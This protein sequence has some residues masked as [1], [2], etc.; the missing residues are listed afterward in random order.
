[1]P[2]LARVR[3]L[4]D[5]DADPSVIDQHLDAG[6][7]G[8]LVSPRPGLRVP[9]AVDAFEVAVSLTVGGRRMAAL[10]RRLSEPIDTGL[11]S[12]DR[13]PLSAE[14]V[15]DARLSTLTAAQLPRRLAV[16]VKTLARR[17]ADGTLSL[18]EHTA[19]PETLERL[20]DLPEIDRTTAELI[21]MRAMRWPDAFPATALRH[22]AGGLSA[23]AL[24][25]RAERWRPWRAYAAMRL[26]STV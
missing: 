21:A 24:A 6:G 2:L 16:C 5:L 20:L 4:V 25:A 9:G 7:L 8:A 11:P 1:M 26:W 22:A 19:V 10:T 3:A 14:R 17:V 12:L 18:D 15:A 23:K 13:L